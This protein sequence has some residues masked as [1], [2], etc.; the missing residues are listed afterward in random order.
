MKRIALLICLS[1]VT[2]LTIAK[3]KLTTYTGIIKGYTPTLE[4]KTANV[5]VWDVV[6]GVLDNYEI[7]IEK[8]GRFSVNFPLSIDKECWV[9]FPFFGG[10][11]YF[12]AG[13]A[14]IQ[15]FDLSDASRV[16]YNFHGEGS[17]INEDLDKVRSI[18]WGYN[19]D[20][21]YADIYQNTPDQYKAYFLKMQAQK[22][23]EIDSVAKKHVLTKRAYALAQYGVKY[24]MAYMIS[25]YN[26]KIQNAYRM[27]HNIPYKDKYLAYRY[28][29][30][31]PVYYDYLQKLTYNDQAAMGSIH[32]REFVYTLESL[33]IVIDKIGRVD[34]SYAIDKLKKMDTTDNNIKSQ[35]KS[36]TLLMMYN[37]RLSANDSIRPR[38]LKELIKKDIGLE[39]ELMSLQDSCRNI[40]HQKVP[41]SDAR[42]ARLKSNLKNRH[43]FEH[44]L[45][46]NNKVKQMIA[47][48]KTQTGF[49]NNETPKVAA[50][51]VFNQIISKYKGKVILVDFWATWCAPCLKGMREIKP[52]KEE[53]KDQEVVFLYI[54][55]P[56]SPETTYK[57][58]ILSI[59]GEHYRLTEPEYLVIRDRLKITGIPHYTIIN[60]KGEIVDNGSHVV[61]LEQLKTQLSQLIK[62]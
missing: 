16:S 3:T 41:L 32:Y 57:A 43:L 58:M 50:D 38:V 59:K 15:N 30:L 36:Y 39:L 5:E 9:T 35:I 25:S 47:D 24:K 26:D 45:L 18:L 27:R 29:K 4:T 52:L 54:T 11:V 14:V 20:S 48:S 22:L 13:K 49:T 53:L 40:H 31:E 51:S 19:W 55:N 60:K 2:T 46:L 10:T 7:N 56:T 12:T 33:D 21:V 44:V 28:V 61:N 62:Q 42:L 17:K 1:L 6:T 23:S 34:Y 8:G 37:E